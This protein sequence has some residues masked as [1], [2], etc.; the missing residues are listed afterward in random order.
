[1]TSRLRVNRPSGGIPTR[2]DRKSLFFDFNGTGHHE[3]LL[4]GQ[5]VNKKYYLQRQRRLREIIRKEQP[6]LCRPYKNR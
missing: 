2:Q 5:T 6:D 4:R 3:F 1:M